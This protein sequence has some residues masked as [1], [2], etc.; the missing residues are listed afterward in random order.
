MYNPLLIIYTPL[1]EKEVAP[2]LL[3]HFLHIILFSF[4]LYA[5]VRIPAELFYVIGT[6]FPIT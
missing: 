2:P 4:A 3:F 6:K 5:A 1:I